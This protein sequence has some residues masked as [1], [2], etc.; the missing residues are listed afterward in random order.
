MFERFYQAFGSG[1]LDAVCDCISEDFE[2]RLPKGPDRPHG[3][4]V[5][6]HEGFRKI[7]ASER[8]ELIKRAKA[9]NENV[10]ISGNQIAQRYRIQAKLPDGQ[11]VDTYG[12][13][14]YT[15]KN[16]KISSKDAYWKAFS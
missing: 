7:Y 16:G 6:G 4:V 8:G 15:V 3:M 11:V 2:W 9:W 14:Y 5:T 12:F 10:F 13:D 1:D